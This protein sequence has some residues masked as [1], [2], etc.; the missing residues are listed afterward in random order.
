MRDTG[1]YPIVVGILFAL[2]G[3]TPFA[4]LTRIEKLYILA[5]NYT[6]KGRRPLGARVRIQR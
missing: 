4:D 5:I 2:S 1:F 6:S 3:K